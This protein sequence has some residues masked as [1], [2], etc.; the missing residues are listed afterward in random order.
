M[1]KM[2]LF[3]KLSKKQSLNNSIKS[4]DNEGTRPAAIS[5]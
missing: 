1:L 2:L 4:L 5:C 3:M